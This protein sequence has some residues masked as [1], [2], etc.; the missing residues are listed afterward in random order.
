M[1]KK[2]L[3]HE[4]LTALG[5]TRLADLLLEVSTGSA[6]IKRRLRLELSHN[7]GA[8]ELGRDVQKRLIAIAKTKT[9][10]GWRKRKSLVKDLQTQVDMIC[11]KIAP[12]APTMAFDLLWEFIALA[13]SVYGRVDD[14]RGEV[15]AVFSAASARF[16]QIAPLAVLDQ[17]DL[18]ARVWAAIQDDSYGEFDDIITVVAPALGQVGLTQLKS[19]I[20]AFQDGP[21]DDTPDHAAIQFLR[22][23]RDEDSPINSRKDRLAK[24]WLQDIAVIEQDADTYVAQFSDRE[25]GRPDIAAEVAMIWQSADRNFEA[26]DLLEGADDDRDATWDAAYISCLQAAGRVDE[27]QAHRWLRFEQALDVDHLRAYLKPLPDFDDVTVE[28]RARAYAMTYPTFHIALGFFI[29]WPDLIG[30]ARLVHDRI[31]EADGTLY[32][33]LTPAIEALRIRHPRAAAL[34]L[35]AVIDDVLD[36]GRADRYA[37]AA[38]HMA[39]L[40]HLDGDIDDYDQFAAH[41]DYAAQLRSR[42]GHANGFWGLLT[43][44]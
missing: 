21:R 29:A 35:R 10:A 27:A 40:A 17:T 42:H 20:A 33:R 9:R 11:D 18:A 37:D 19:Y 16:A 8:E 32:W 14:S 13:P 3:N 7:L 36:H 39:D 24:G 6:D 15:H 4:N 34:L 25:L 5:P 2:T 22:T 31:L 38:A 28:D 41:A 12:D 44:S 26:I 23:L 30:A 43:V 1:S